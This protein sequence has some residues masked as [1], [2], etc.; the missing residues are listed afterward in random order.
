MINP[1][2]K[3]Y[4]S[5]YKEIDFGGKV[6]YELTGSAYALPFE[7]EPTKGEHNYTTC[8]GCKTNLANYKKNL[9][10]KYE[11]REGNN[12]FPIC[13]E[14]HSKLPTLNEYNREDFDKVPEMVAMKIIYVENHI[15]NNIE[16]ENW[17]EEITDYLECALMSFGQFPT[18]YGGP[19]FKEDFVFY[20]SECIKGG[21]AILEEKKEKLL[22]FFESKN[23]NSTYRKSKNNPIDMSILM[24][25]YNKWLKLFP[26]EL[27]SYFGNL[28]SYYEKNIHILKD[29]PKVNK[30]S[31]LAKSQLHTK[32]SLFE[33]LTDI[34]NNLLTQ[35]NGSALYEQGLITDS[36]KLKLELAIG[37]RKLKIEQGYK[38]DSPNEERRYI[39]MIKSWFR[40]E[41]EFIVEITPLLKSVNLDKV[42]NTNPKVEITLSDI[43]NSENKFWKGIPMQIVVTHFEILSKRRNKAGNIYLTT[44]QLISFLKKGFLNDNTQLKQKINCINGEKGFI[45]KR[46]YEFFVLAVSQYGYPQRKEKF[47]SMFLNCF[48]NWNKSTIAP[49]FKPNKTNEMW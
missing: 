11:G 22:Q 36:N 26:F 32:E 16:S 25:T 42:E 46:F 1:N 10:D 40:D 41:K 28:K 38:N 19:L 3:F 21:N 49:F 29:A 9:Q 4:V 14:G 17:Y 7:I 33:A 34:T 43:A 8:E 45:I 23:V 39:R 6:G 35:I 18:G 12:P 37:K 13:C 15:Q 47:I 20:V 30:Y 2:I 5:D 44:D 27:N 31:G 48:D 24:S